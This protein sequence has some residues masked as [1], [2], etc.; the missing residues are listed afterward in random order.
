MT[1]GLEESQWL[2]KDQMMSRNQM[3]FLLDEL[4]SNKFQKCSN[5]RDR[6]RKN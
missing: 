3:I 4:K 2:F 6:L 1:Y 5:G